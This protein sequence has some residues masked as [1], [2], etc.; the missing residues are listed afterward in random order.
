MHRVSGCVT[1]KPT[2]SQYRCVTV[3]GVI[4]PRTSHSL[5]R[6][7]IIECNYAS[8]PRQ[9]S[10][11][12]SPSLVCRRFGTRAIDARG[13]RAIVDNCQLAELSRHI[14]THRYRYQVYPLLRAR[15]AAD[16]CS[17]RHMCIYVTIISNQTLIRAVGTRHAQMPLFRY[18]P[19]SIFFFGGAAD[20]RWEGEPF[21]CGRK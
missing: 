5:M 14:A 15:F 19:S 8:P 1:P 17:M 20:P 11:F 12:R 10:F 21:N 9:I 16:M 13:R 18:W 6:D 7:K 3:R 2:L 4:A